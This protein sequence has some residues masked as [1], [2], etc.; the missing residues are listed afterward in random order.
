M[1]KR[2]LRE[3]LLGK[4]HFLGISCGAY[5]GTGPIMCPQ[6]YPVPPLKPSLVEEQVERYRAQMKKRAEDQK[7]L[8]QQRLHFPKKKIVP[9]G[10]L[11]EMVDRLAQPKKPAADT[12]TDYWGA[13]HGS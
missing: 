4:S 3:R 2:P 1:H 6:N 5:G 8:E 13:T 9:A 10:D 12:L 11:Q 7:R